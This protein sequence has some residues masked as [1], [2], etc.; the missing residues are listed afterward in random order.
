MT[1]KK[2]NAAAERMTLSSVAARCADQATQIK[3]SVARFLLQERQNRFVFLIAA[4]CPDREG[5]QENAKF[6]IASTADFRDSE[7]AGSECC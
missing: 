5:L 7:R 6:I 2:P 4:I 3:H 1:A